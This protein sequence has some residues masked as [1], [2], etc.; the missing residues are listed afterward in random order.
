MVEQLFGSKTRIKLL[1][2]FM[3]NPNRSFYVRE[4]TRKIDEQINSVRRELSNLHEIGIITSDN[5]SHKRYY[6]VNQKYRHYKALASI[7]STNDEKPTAKSKPK[8]TGSVIESLGEIEFMALSGIFT[9]DS[10]SPADLMIV[11][12]VNKKKLDSYI[13]ELEESKGRE[14]RFAVFDKKEAEYRKMVHDRFMVKMLSSKLS[15]KL[16]K[17]GLLNDGN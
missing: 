10:N 8:S 9:R 3:S 17:M 15:V 2:L 14:I 7:F 4:I 1:K 16:D 11:G 13:L 5:S 6:E 12:E